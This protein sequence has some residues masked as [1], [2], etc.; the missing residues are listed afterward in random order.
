MQTRHNTDKVGRATPAR[1]TRM[2]PL[3]AAA[4][5]DGH[6][7]QMETPQAGTNG[8]GREGQTTSNS[9]DCAHPGSNDQPAALAA[10]LARLESAGFTVQRSAHG[11]L[12][13]RWGWLYAAADA[14][15]LGA[16]ARRVGVCRD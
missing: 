8:K 12:V 9:A 3:G 16:F 4:T 10:L 7:A 15:D 11:F 2:A 5:G 1:S 13:T 6:L 14:A